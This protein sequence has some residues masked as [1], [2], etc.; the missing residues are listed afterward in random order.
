[1]LADIRLAKSLARAFAFGITCAE[2]VAVN[3]AAIFLVVKV[4]IVE[5]LAVNFDARHENKPLNLFPA[6]ELQK[7]VRAQNICRHCTDG[8]SRIKERMRIARR[9]DYEV[10]GEIAFNRRVDIELDE[11]KI[12]IANVICKAFV[13]D[14]FIAPRRADFDV[15]IVGAIFLHEHIDKHGADKPARA[16]Q[17]QSLARQ[18]FPR[19]IFTRNGIYIRVVNFM[20]NVHVVTLLEP[21]RFLSG[22]E[23]LENFNVVDG[24]DLD[25]FIGAAREVKRLA[26]VDHHRVDVG[27]AVNPNLL[28]ERLLVSPIE[29]AE[30][31]S[32]RSL[33]AAQGV[34]VDI[35]LSASLV[36]LAENLFVVGQA[37]DA[38]AVLPASRDNVGKDFLINH[39]A[40]PV[41]NDNNVVVLVLLLNRE[42]AVARGLLNCRAA[43]DDFLQLRDVVL[44]GIG[45]KNILPAVEAHDKDTVDFGVLLKVFKRVNQY[46]L[47]VNV[48]ELL[49]NVLARTLP[50]PRR[51]NQCYCT[52]KFFL[53]KLFWVIKE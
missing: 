18:L 32:L 2:R 24:R 44:A 11:L 12:F 25:I 30:L 19:Q 5:S 26:Q 20:I 13:G 1:M 29:F 37:R 10:N 36:E 4:I 17:E 40:N 3:V 49:W 48:N 22:N 53:L 6:P 9:V 45:A 16:R 33:D 47:V 39:R 42:D 28:L 15:E 51:K 43:V 8:I 38:V 46:R 7:I 31:V 50:L 14:F 35:F 23:R 41:V 21:R 27:G 52:H 34:T